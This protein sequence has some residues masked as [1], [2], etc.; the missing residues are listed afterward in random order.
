M[1]P[2]DNK[3]LIRALRGYAK[4]LAKPYES[5]DEDFEE[6]GAVWCMKEAAN[7]IKEQGDTITRLM[8]K[9]KNR[10]R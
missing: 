5:R 9:L 4:E 1:K 10:D 8:D 2:V 6:D 7:R 3:Y